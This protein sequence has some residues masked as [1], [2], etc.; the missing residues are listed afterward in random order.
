VHV[1]AT[2]LGAVDGVI[3]TVV[4]GL[5]AVDGLNVDGDSGR[6]AMGAM[7]VLGAIPGLM[8]AAAPMV[9][10]NSIYALRLRRRI[11]Q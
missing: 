8:A 3:A 2:A 6:G 1:N 7:D 5:N 4:D 10:E 9:F 11:I